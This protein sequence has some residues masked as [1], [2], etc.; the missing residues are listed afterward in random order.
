MGGRAGSAGGKGVDRR[1]FESA[2]Y[3]QVGLSEVTDLIDFAV[4]ARLET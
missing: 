2:D 4:L 1:L 3:H